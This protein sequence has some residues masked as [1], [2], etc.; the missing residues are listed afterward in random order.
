MIERYSQISEEW[1]SP[2]AADYQDPGDL[3]S[4]LL[5]P[6]CEDEFAV[7]RE[8]K[9]LVTTDINCGALTNT[10]RFSREVSYI[11]S[12][13]VSYISS[14]RVSYIS[15]CEVSYIS[16]HRVSYISSCEVSYISSCEVS[17]I[18]SHKV[19]YISSSSHPLVVRL[20]F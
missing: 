20:I 11:S 13:E 2:V 9:S 10:L 6:G 17:Y 7:I 3:R 5:H 4:W 16:S 12:S 19:S 8:S 14:S 18:S 1:D 15:S